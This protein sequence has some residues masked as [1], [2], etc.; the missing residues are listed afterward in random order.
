MKVKSKRI[1]R[2]QFLGEVN[3]GTSLGMAATALSAIGSTGCAAL[4]RYFEIEKLRYDKEVLIFGAGVAG[5][6]SAY[7]LKK[8]RIPYRI[9]EASSRTGGRILTQHTSEEGKYYDF[10]AFQFNEFDQNVLSLLKDLNLEIDDSEASS[11]RNSFSFLQN[12]FLLPFKQIYQIENKYFQSWHRE[13]LKF[14]KKSEINF[15]HNWLL[16]EALIEYDKVFLKDIFRDAKVSPQNSKLLTKWA[17]FFFQKPLEEISFLSWL[18]LVEKDRIIGNK[19]RIINGMEELTFHLTQRVGGV[20]PNYNL[21]L[22]AQ[23]L[24]IQRAN[25]NWICQVH[26]QE[27]IK[28][29]SAPYVILALPFTELKKIK[30]IE[31]IFIN[32]ELLGLIRN[33]SNLNT[34]TAVAEIK[35]KNIKRPKLL[36][37]FLSIDNKTFKF[38]LEANHVVF[39]FNSENDLDWFLNERN[40]LM[41]FMSAKDFEFVNAVN[42]RQM[43]YIHGSS[44]NLSTASSL[45][46]KRS[47]QGDWSLSSLQ[48]AGDYLSLPVPS[49]LDDTIL[50]AKTAVN[51]ILESYQEKVRS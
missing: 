6:S 24:E 19:L 7:Y 4:D 33:S 18:M 50:S 10:G 35:S 40:L 20:I 22:P 39:N 49:N 3:K 13:L 32:Q 28:K 42:W 34:V 43:K 15:N 46:L 16:D 9:F 41:N 2:R 44:L 8:N 5:L 29:I 12:Q 26:T 48:L 17:E 11:L 31:N 30:G 14:Q 38:R 36:K 27:G 47:L 21:Q 23:L 37:E 45:D 25:D 51:N 1:T